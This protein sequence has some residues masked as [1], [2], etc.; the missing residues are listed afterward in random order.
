M[1]HVPDGGT[2][3]S[4]QQVE[5]TVAAVIA[6]ERHPMANMANTASVLGHMVT[7]I[8]WAGFYLVD[9]HAAANELVLGPFWG[10]PA[11]VR[12]AFGRGVC[13]T[14]AVQRESII[15]DDV[16]AFPGHIAC[17][18]ASRSEL[19]IPM[20]IGDHLIGVL[21]LDSPELAR[22]TEA[23]RAGA[24]RVAHLVVVGSDWSMI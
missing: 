8:N 13:G 12:I 14:T 15:V 2:H 1:F 5:Q 19:V 3:T 22:F 17:D 23:D 6:G 18:A 21:D 9:R 10:K 4:W 7:S 11:C 24:E 20:V 16:E